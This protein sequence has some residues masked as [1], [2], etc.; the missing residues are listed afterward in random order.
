MRLLSF[1]PDPYCR[2]MTNVD[3]Q[4]KA[5]DFKHLGYQFILNVIY[6]DQLKIIT[7]SKSVDIHS[8]IG[9][10]GGYI[11]LFLGKHNHI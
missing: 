5:I 8:F 10:I 7:Q 1:D 3:F 4:T 2:T 6:P 11:G 9:N